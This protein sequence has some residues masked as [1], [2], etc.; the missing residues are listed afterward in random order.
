M[1]RRGWMLFVSM[2]LIWGIPYLLIKVADGGVAPAVLVLARVTIGA[3]ILIPIAVGRR[4]LAPLLPYWRWLILFALVEII[5]PWL[6]LSEAETRLSSSLSGLLIASVPI[7]VAVFGR[8]TGGQERLTPIR[9]AGLLV[10]LGGVALLVVGNGTHG[11]AGSVAEVLGVAVCYSI[12]PL[13]VARKLS[14]LPSLG[15]TAACLAFAAVVYAPIA[16]LAWPQ[17]MPSGQVVAALAG[18]AVVCT[19]VAFVLFFALIAEAGPARASV[20]TYV[21]PAVAVILGIAVLGE[22]LTATMAV[23]FLL[24]LGGSVLATRKASPADGGAG[25]SVAGDGAAGGGVAGRGEQPDADR[26][27]TARYES[28]TP[29]LHD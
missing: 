7:L 25:G 22:K 8:L 13:I 28:A 4:E 24:I 18:L 5:T 23:A 1:S 21:N 9:W 29:G 3:A 15:M 2:S 20:I 16:A 10:G 27:L 26:S 6:L 19:A 14:E 11:D 12:G 17:A